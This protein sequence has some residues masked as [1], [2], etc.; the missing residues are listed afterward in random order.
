E[1]LDEMGTLEDLRAE[2][3]AG[4]LGPQQR[5]FEA[6]PSLAVASQRHGEHRLARRRG[7]ILYGPAPQPR[8]C[9]DGRGPIRIAEGRRRSEPRSETGRGGAGGAPR[10]APRARALSLEP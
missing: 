7:R 10:T 6:G 2:V 5:V 8:R 3:G 4:E 9:A 1:R